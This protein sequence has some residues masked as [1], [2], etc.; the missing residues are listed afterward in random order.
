MKPSLQ[1]LSYA[2]L[3]L[4]W[5]P[6]LLLDSSF[7]TDSVMDNKIITS[8]IVISLWL[9]LFIKVEASLKKMMLIMVPLSWLGEV[10]CS[11]WLDM[12]RYRN[13][14]IPLYVPFGHAVIYITGFLF[15]HLKTIQRHKSIIKRGLISIFVGLFLMV[16]VGFNDSLSALLGI[17][18]FAILHLKKY[19]MLYLV[20]SVLV[21]YLEILGTQFGTWSWH[22]EWWIFTTVNPPVG[23]IF[24][25]IAGDMLLKKITWWSQ[26][27][28]KSQKKSPII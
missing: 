5:I 17:L 13:E 4:I 20:M 1:T 21:L 8:T 27:Y 26:K 14:G 3:I 24:I 22:N 25:Y 15:T 16:T 10:I 2:L 23:A 12:Y 18:F 28:R 9:F 11:L 6:A 7:I 19:P